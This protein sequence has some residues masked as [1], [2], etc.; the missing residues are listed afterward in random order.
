MGGYGDAQ[1]A[2]RLCSESSNKGLPMPK[3]DVEEQ[4]LKLSVDE[5][6]SAGHLSHHWPNNTIWLGGEYKNENWFWDDGK[7]IGIYTAAK[8]KLDKIGAS[9]KH[10]QDAEPWLA[11]VLHGE[12]HDSLSFHHFGIMCK[13]DAVTEV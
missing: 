12:W 4:E 7:P 11:M 10:N 3:R 1:D 5:A 2:R 6:L 13:R 8:E 9:S